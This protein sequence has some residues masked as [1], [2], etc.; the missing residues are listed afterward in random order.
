MSILITFVGCSK[1][2]TTK[3]VFQG[4]ILTSPFKRNGKLTFG[5]SFLTTASKSSII[6]TFGGV[7]RRT[8]PNIFFKDFF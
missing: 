4:W 5:G 8:H 1:I 6:M 2:T 7:L 3:C